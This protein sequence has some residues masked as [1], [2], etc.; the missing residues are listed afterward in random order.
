MRTTGDL[1]VVCGFLKWVVLGVWLWLWGMASC[2]VVMVLKWAGADHMTPGDVILAW[3]VIL[4]V[5][6]WA[7]F[8]F[9][10]LV[11]DAV[12]GKCAKRGVR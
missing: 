7:W 1:C 4:M 8:I 11:R 10:E 3:M 2:G 6:L 9:T 5:F 12:C